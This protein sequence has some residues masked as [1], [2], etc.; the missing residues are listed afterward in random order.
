ME[1]DLTWAVLSGHRGGLEPKKAKEQS[2][3]CEFYV[4]S[5]NLR[6]GFSIKWLVCLFL[7]HANQEELTPVT[8]SPIKT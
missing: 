4:Y 5:G 3:C 2:C 8:T 7:F 6:L 1:D